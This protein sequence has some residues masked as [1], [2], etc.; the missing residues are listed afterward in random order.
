VVCFAFQATWL[1]KLPGQRFRRMEMFLE[2]VISKSRYRKVPKNTI[3]LEEGETCKTFV[4]MRKGIIRHFFTD[5]NGDDISKNFITAP[6]DFFYSISSFLTQTPSSVMCE[7]LSEVEI[8]E[9][10]YEDFQ[11]LLRN[12]EFQ[13]FWSDTLSKFIIKKENKEISLLKD[14]ALHRYENFLKDFPGLLNEIPHY[15][16]AS[17]L[18]IN[19]ETLSR[20]RKQIS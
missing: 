5:Q 8:F 20:I 2:G 10:K 15:Y 18:S 17:Y 12:S 13:S 7:S 3:L 19:P 14:S 1:P 6:G 16:I 9:L 11:E 4:H